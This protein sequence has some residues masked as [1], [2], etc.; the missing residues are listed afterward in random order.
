MIT[1]ESMAK[2]ASAF[3][4]AFQA[5]KQALGPH[6]I[7]KWGW[8]EAY[9]RRVHSE[10]WAAKSFFRIVFE[11]EAVGTVAIDEWP[12]HVQIGEFYLL[13]EFQRKGIGGKVLATVME[14]SIQRQLPL[15]LEC[16][17]W[18]PALSLYQRAGFVVTSESDTHFFMERYR[19]GGRATA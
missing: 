17:K 7:V 1:L 14:R 4:F 16:L 8:D 15:R 19:G 9:Q 10:R 6:I 2:D 5:K 18:N 13:P 12:T 3:E 11:G